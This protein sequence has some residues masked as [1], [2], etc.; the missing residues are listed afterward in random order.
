ME[1]EFD[2]E[3]SVRATLKREY[4]DIIYK[5]LKAHPDT[6]I[7]TT[8]GHFG[9]AFVN[10]FKGEDVET[11]FTF[12]SIDTMCKALEYPERLLYST[13]DE[14]SKVADQKKEIYALF[15]SWIKAR[16]DEYKRITKNGK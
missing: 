1:I 14:T 3:I 10:Y 9:F 15:H 2:Y 4:A 12:K 11:T 16:A 6:E 13:L 5:H 8:Q 7:H